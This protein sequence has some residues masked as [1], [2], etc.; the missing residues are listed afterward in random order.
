MSQRTAKAT[1]DVV[2]RLTQIRAITL[3]VNNDP[4]LTADE[5]G[6]EFF[7][8]ILDSL[9]GKSVAQLNLRKINPDKVLLYIKDG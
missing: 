3:A 8:A 9:E 6:A 2:R 4:D 5:C 1:T 7:Y